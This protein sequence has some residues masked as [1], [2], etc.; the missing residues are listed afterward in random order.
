GD[1]TAYREE[2]S[3]L[4]E[5]C[6]HNNLSLNISNT[7]EMIVDYRKLQRGGHSPLTWL[8]RFGLPPD[9]LTNFYRCT[10]ESIPVWYGSCTAYNR[11]AL[12]RVVRTA[13]SII[14]SKLPD[15][16]DVYQSHPPRTSTSPTPLGHLPVPLPEDIYQS[17]C[18]RTVTSPTA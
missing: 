14:G 4:S 5:W 2:V 16:Q 8:M 12:K 18:L 6:Y 15:L 17:R 1:E 10:I 7:K 13:E 3:A 11:K 9:I